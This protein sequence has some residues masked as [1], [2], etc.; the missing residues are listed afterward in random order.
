MGEQKRKAA[1][2]HV[3]PEGMMNVSGRHVVDLARGIMDLLEK[4]FDE[5]MQA[6]IA[7]HVMVVTAVDLWRAN[8]GDA[9]VADALKGA[10]DRRLEKPAEYWGGKRGA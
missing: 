8:Y 3:P 10:I 4:P 9:Q 6:D 2:G 1:A 7:A 5:G